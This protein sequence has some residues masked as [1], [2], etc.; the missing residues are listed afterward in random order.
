MAKTISSLSILNQIARHDMESMLHDQKGQSSYNYLGP[1][2]TEDM[3]KEI[4]R[5]NPFSRNRPK[6]TFYD[7]SRGSPF[8]GM[9]LQKLEKFVV[10]NKKNFLRKFHEKLL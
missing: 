7:K 8:S 5:V 3:R 9:T 6:Q 2:K 10:R 4:E 1:L